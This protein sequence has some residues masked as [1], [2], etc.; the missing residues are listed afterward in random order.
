MAGVWMSSSLSI[1]EAQ[2]GSQALR[3]VPNGNLRRREA[4]A[5][6]VNSTT[7]RDAARP[8]KADATPMS[9]RCLTP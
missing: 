7:S 1:W 3:M 2:G 5:V 4:M 9:E 6:A 8:T